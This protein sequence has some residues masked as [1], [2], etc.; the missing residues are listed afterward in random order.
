MFY[1]GEIL[2]GKKRSFL[3]RKYLELFKTQAN[4]N[5]SLVSLCKLLKIGEIKRHNGKSEL[6][7]VQKLLNF[8]YQVRQSINQYKTLHV[9]SRKVAH[10]TYFLSNYK[11]QNNIIQYQNEQHLKKSALSTE[12]W[13]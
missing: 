4:L 10:I 2:Y 12:V 9:K 5:E 11:S 13:L 6:V 3:D 7:T 8:M 1:V